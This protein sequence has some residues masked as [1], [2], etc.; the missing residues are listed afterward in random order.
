M[1][2]GIVRSLLLAHGGGIELVP[3]Q[4]GARFRI[5]VPLVGKGT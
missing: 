1:G 2:L 4:A 5:V 3:S